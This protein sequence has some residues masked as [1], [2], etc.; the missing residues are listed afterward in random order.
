M[1]RVSESKVR[2]FERYQLKKAWGTFEGRREVGGSFVR[3]T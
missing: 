1:G 3:V 2:L